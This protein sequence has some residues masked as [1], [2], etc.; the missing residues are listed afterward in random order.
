MKP[1][2]RLFVYLVPVMFIL[3]CIVAQAQTDTTRIEISEEVEDVSDFYYRSRYEYLDLNMKQDRSLVKLGLFPFIPD[4]NS[5]FSTVYL[6]AAYE[7]KFGK[8]FS[9]AREI[10]AV[11]SISNK[12]VHTTNTGF[13]ISC[14]YYYGMKKRIVEGNGAD[15]LNGMYFSFGLRRLAVYST[16]REYDNYNHS[17]KSSS[18]AVKPSVMIAAGYQKRLTR[19]L[20]MD[21]Q[22]FGYWN[23]TRPVLG[24]RILLGIAFNPNDI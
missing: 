1:S 18:L 19:L 15:N 14:R 9:I 16:T 6:Q 17:T 21:T 13:D 2:K 23:N 10:N 20:F 12:R 7:T 3:T 22:A 24:V 5:D 4:L 11:Y 8:Q